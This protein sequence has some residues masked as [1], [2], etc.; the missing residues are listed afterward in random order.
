MAY[1]PLPKYG[2]GTNP[3]DLTQ[4]FNNLMGEIDAAFQ[5]GAGTGTVTQVNTANGITGG[6]ISVSGT[7]GLDNINAGS[8]L[9]NISG[10]SAVPVGNTVTS[11]LDLLASTQGDIL[12]R[13]GSSWVGLLPG[14][15]GQVLTAHGPGI[16]LS[17]TNTGAG[18]FAFS[19][20]WNASA[21][22]PA[23]SSGVGS[24]GNVWVVTTPGG[25][26]L[27]G[28]SEWMLNDWAV[29]DGLVWRKV[30]GVN[31]NSGSYQRDYGGL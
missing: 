1:T 27:D 6:P 4:E 19:G 16:N 3:A 17:W 9:S 22:S 12:I 29:F 13:S 18:T 5:G 15:A 31:A 21:N 7:V 30:N 10:F 25:T 11:I 23:L 28:I 14:S 8:V 26:T 20:N 2:T 24:S